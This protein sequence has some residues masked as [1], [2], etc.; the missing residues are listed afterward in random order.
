MFILQVILAVGPLAVYFLGLG[1]V[2]SQGHPVMVNAR[3]DFTLLTIAFFPL[4]IIPVIG[5]IGQNLAWLGLAIITAILVAFFY[6]RPG[7]RQ[8]WVIY[9]M[10]IR[11]CRRLLIQACRQKGWSVEFHEDRL[12]VGP[13][14][15]MIHFEHFPLLNNVT[16][17]IA[18]GE[19]NTNASSTHEQL[20]GLLQQKLNAQC[21]L[22]SMAGAGLVIIGTGLLGLPLWYMFYH[23]QAIVEVVREILFA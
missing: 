12:A 6:V 1:L 8:G 5:L 22:P 11:R 2:N 13:G 16:L 17:Q 4:I 23:M 9:N 20:V 7:R 14:L 18:P 21:T 3:A 15:L 10:D 19:G